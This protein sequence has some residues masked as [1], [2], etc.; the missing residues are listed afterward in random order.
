MGGKAGTEPERLFWIAA[1][2][3]GVGA[4][5]I[6]GRAAERPER[7]DH[8]RGLAESAHGHEE[9]DEP[10]PGHGQTLPAPDRAAEV[11]DRSGRVPFEFSDRRLCAHWGLPVGALHGSL[12]EKLPC[13][14]ERLLLVRSERVNVRAVVAEP[15]GTDGDDLL[16][17]PRDVAD[18]RLGA[19]LL[20]DQG[21]LCGHLV[22]IIAIGS[23]VNEHHP[24][25]HVVGIVGEDRL[26]HLPCG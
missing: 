1:G 7:R 21:R 4:D 10:T 15:G 3:Q 17:G 5:P 26:G 14:L 13:P 20:L 12:L 18:R 9:N 23:D 6:D 19:E 22:G 8:R 2:R 16:H 25:L 24:H 11:P